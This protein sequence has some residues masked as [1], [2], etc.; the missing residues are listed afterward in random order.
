MKELILIIVLSGLWL[1][2]VSAQQ[3]KGDIREGNRQ[4]KSEKFEDS[5]ISYR[6]ALDVQDGSIPA[7]FNLGDA[8]YRQEKFEEA[9]RQFAAV[10]TKN[11]SKEVQSQAYHNLGNSLLQA[12][13]LDESI[14]AFKQALRLNPDD[15]ETKYN[16]A[17]AQNLK[18][19]QEQ[20]K[21]ENQDQDQD[22]N[23]DQEKNEDQKQNQDQEG[24]QKEDQQQQQQQQ[25]QNDQQQK[26]QQKQQQEQEGKISKEDAKRMIAA[27]AN[28]EKETMEK[29]KKAK[30]K[31][32]R[33]RTLKDW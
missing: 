25:E 28:D 29:V 6:K 22:Q 1:S 10:R 18:K 24:D 16:L 3:Y 11:T 19:Q 2:N 13:K 14:E 27:L 26:E 4:F 23:Q 30:A 15:M 32:K 8:L 20:E 17:Y 12:S 7:T 5:E 31:A 33:V 21:Q 9:G